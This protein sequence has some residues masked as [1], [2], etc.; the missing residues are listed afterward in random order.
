METR[1]EKRQRDRDYYWRNRELISIKKRNRI[2]R[3]LIK[4]SEKE[5]RS[6]V[7]RNQKRRAILKNL[8]NS[9]TFDQWQYCQNYFDNKCCY[10]GADAPLTTRTLHSYFENGSIY[11]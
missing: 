4:V 7:V 11:G 1:E 5:K 6:K 9:Y 2:S 3:G 10:C 8:P